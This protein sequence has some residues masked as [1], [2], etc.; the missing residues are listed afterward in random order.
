MKKKSAKSKAPERGSDMLMT[1]G[2][3][4]EFREEMRAG[5]RSIDRKLKSHDDKFLSHDKR[6]DSI[7]KKFESIDKRFESMSHKI[8]SVRNE[9][10]SD[11]EKVLEETRRTRMLTEEQNNRTNVVLDGLAVLFGRQER[12]EKRVDDVERTME[13]FKKTST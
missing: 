2:I 3:L 7:D 13:N 8:D 10:K 5:F 6:F 12:V 1:V 4:E 9:L 11:I